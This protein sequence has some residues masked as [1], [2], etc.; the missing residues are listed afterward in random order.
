MKKV[1]HKIPIQGCCQCAYAK[2]F[3]HDLI[4]TSPDLKEHTFAV[5]FLQGR[6]TGLKMGACG[7]PD[8]CPLPTYVKTVELDKMVTPQYIK[9]S[10]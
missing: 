2:Y 1:C 4:C 6:L 10:L 7:F 9:K 5:G 3:K 8:Y